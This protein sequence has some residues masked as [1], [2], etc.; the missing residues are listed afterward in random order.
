[1][2]HLVFAQQV[3]ELGQCIQPDIQTLMG[4][5]LGGLLELSLEV[6]LTGR[7]LPVF[8]QHRVDLFQLSSIRHEVQLVEVLAEGLPMKRQTTEADKRTCLPFMG[9]PYCV[10]LPEVLRVKA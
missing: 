10:M 7:V 2:S 9:L 6:R 5:P 3:S 1:M 4:D 8:L